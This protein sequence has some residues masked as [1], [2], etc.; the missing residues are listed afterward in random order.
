MRVGEAGADGAEGGEGAPQ[1]LVQVEGQPLVPQPAVVAQVQVLN[2]AWW[3]CQ[4]NF[5]SIG[6]KSG[7]NSGS[8]VARMAKVKV[9]LLYAK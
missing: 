3:E 2:G 4:P 1:V 5:I 8:E 9:P 6:L 7:P